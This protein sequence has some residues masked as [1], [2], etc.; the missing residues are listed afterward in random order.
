MMQSN[1]GHIG[2]SIVAA[3]SLARLISSMLCEWGRAELTV[4]QAQMFSNDALEREDSNTRS[5]R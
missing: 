3:Y 2:S 1:I 4:D 5:L